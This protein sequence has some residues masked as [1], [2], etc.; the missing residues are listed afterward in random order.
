M[1]TLLS[2][3]LFI[4]PFFLVQGQDL[5]VKAD[6]EE[7]IAKVVEIKSNKI[8]YYLYDNQFGDPLTIRKDDIYMIIYEDGMRQF[9]SD[10]RSANDLLGTDLSEEQLQDLY[11]KGIEDASIYHDKQGLLWAAMGATVYFP[12]IG[13]F[14]GGIL[15]AIVAM[16]PPN[17]DIGDVPNAELYRNPYYAEG[18]NKQVQKHRVKKAL[19]GF[20][21]GLGIQ[22]T[23]FLIILAS[24]W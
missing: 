1:K 8:D 10:P 12:F 22:A 17:L 13:I 3:L 18:Y 14:T 4:S 15:V 21:I 9:F 24:S 5:I 23:L 16:I 20:G 11:F 6:D 2:L 19:Q 7:I